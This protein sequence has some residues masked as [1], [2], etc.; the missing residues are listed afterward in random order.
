MSTNPRAWTHVDRTVYIPAAV[1]AKFLSD[2]CVNPEQL[3]KVASALKNLQPI[4]GNFLSFINQK[5]LPKETK[6]ILRFATRKPGKN[7]VWIKDLVARRQRI[8]DFRG[9][10]GVTIGLVMWDF[11]R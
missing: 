10:A 4:K 2:L 6:V 5:S 1:N 7:L 8:L 9:G 11:K 3:S